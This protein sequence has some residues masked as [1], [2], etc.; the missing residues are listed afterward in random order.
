MEHPAVAAEDEWEKEVVEEEQQPIHRPDTKKAPGEEIGVEARRRAGVE[1]DA[2]D[3]ESG[4]DEEQTDASPTPGDEFFDKCALQAGE[5]V[6]E[7]NGE[8]CDA[9]QSIKCRNEG[10]QPRRALGNRRN[11]RSG[12]SSGSSRCGDCRGHYREIPSKGELAEA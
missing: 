4:E 2:G 3:K 1:N 5:A 6:V 12:S 8:D 9:A 7:E 11:R 10:G